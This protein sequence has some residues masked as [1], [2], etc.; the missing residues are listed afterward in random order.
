M[1]VVEF[2]VSEVLVRT[3]PR[4]AGFVPAANVIAGAAEQADDFEMLTIVGLKHDGSLFVA[5]TS[6]HL[7]DTLLLIERVKKKLME[8]FDDKLSER[9]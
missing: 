9:K 6:V 4:E 5:G 3:A 2:P 1:S 8:P 7:A